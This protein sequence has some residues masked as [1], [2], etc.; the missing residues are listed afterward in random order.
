MLGVGAQCQGV[1]VA[2]GGGAALADRPREPRPVAVWS[3]TLSSPPAPRRE[4]SAV[5]S[6]FSV[7]GSRRL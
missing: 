1:Q 4:C 5:T 2:R 6:G 7:H 3:R